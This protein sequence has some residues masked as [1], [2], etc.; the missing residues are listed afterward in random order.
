[1]VLEEAKR[2]LTPRAIGRPA[3]CGRAGW[4]FS[5][6]SVSSFSKSTEY[7]VEKVRGDSSRVC[8]TCS[9]QPSR[10][11]SNYTWQKVPETWSYM[12]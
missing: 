11:C 7:S 4:R 3:G 2:Q 8:K 12:D 6:G 9:R 10:S 5:K 1:V